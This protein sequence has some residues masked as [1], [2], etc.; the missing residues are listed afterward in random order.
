MRR[1]TSHQES[2]RGA[3]GV[4]VVVMMLVLIGA[5]AMAVDVGEIYAERAQ[6][7]NAADAGALAVA[8][9]CGAGTCNSG[10]AGS[11]ANGNSND[12]SS[13]SAVDLTVP[14]QVTVRTETRDSNGAGFLPKMFASALSAGPV[15][16]GASATAVWESTTAG[17][18]PL[19]FDQCQITPTYAPAGVTVLLKEHGKSPCVGSP[20]G[21]HIPGGFGWLDETGVCDTAADATAWVGSNPGNSK[22]PPD[23]TAT[24]NSWRAAI[25]YSQGQFA[26]AYFPIFDDGDKG[27]SGGRFHL[28]GFAKVEVH[29]WSFVTDDDGLPTGKRDPACSSL[30][31]NSSNRGICGQ[32]QTFIPWSQRGAVNGPYFPKS[33]AHLIN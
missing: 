4:L 10:L 27:G 9:S 33:T 22:T 15:T 30:F 24:L 31:G 11:L 13:S 21:H 14:G 7:Q 29:G 20:S 18:F 12:G 26:T 25:N 17:A 8:Q 5:G 19:V 3:A 2:E 1:L 23:C 16:V 6:L 28:S 32:F